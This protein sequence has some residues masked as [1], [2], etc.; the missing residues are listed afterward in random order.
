MGGVVGKG[1]LGAGF[2]GCG[3]FSGWV[4]RVRVL[5]PEMGLDDIPWAVR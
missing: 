3:D 4:G 2:A 5:M 1:M